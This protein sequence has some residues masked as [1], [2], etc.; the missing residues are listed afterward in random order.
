MAKKIEIE[1]VIGWHDQATPE[2]LSAQ[3]KAANGEDVEVHFNSPGG[4]IGA[5]LKMYNQLRNYT[6]KTTAVLSG[7][8][9]SMASYIPQACDEVMAEDN[10][11]YMIHN[12][13]GGVWGAHNEVQ[14]YGKYLQGLSGITA[15]ELAKQTGKRDKAKSVE[16]VQELMDA[17]TFFF[18]EE[19][20]E[21]GF[22]DSIIQSADG[23]DKET[24]LASAQASF[25]DAQALMASDQGRVKADLQLAMQLYDTDTPPAAPAA[26]IK[27][28]E[29]KQMNLQAL[30]AA[31][32]QAK[33]EYDAAITA[34]VAQGEK[35]GKEEMQATAKAVS[36]FLSNPAYPKQV[37]E[38]AAKVLTGEQSKASL[39]NMV[40]MADMMT[41]MQKGNQAAA[42]T[43]AA[44]GTPGQ[45]QNTAVDPFNVADETGLEAAIQLAAPKGGK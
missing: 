5:G 32:P 12:A 34:A 16:Q 18:G 17:E 25:A 44:G 28:Q 26:G 1:G 37:G 40:M 36:N 43:A 9:M 6:G 11:V 35:A 19:M 42:G 33:A 10:A 30:L 27:T 13:R 39:D 38:M 29:G 8:A 7:Y 41:E 15:R 45:Q 4:L 2:Y 14:K 31:N 21:H 24:A 23:G 3:L 22:V 20:V